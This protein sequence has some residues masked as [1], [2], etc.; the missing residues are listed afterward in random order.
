[1]PDWTALEA[2]LPPAP[3][4]RAR[5]AALAASFAAALELVRNGR[6]DLSQAGAFAPLLLRA[7][8]SPLS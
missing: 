5:R 8:G 6:I 4:S 1:M 2:F 7:R 3:D